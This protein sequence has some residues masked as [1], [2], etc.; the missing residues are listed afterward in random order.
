MCSML[1]DCAKIDELKIEYRIYKKQ[2]VRMSKFDKISAA[3]LKILLGIIVATVIL[4][5][6]GGIYYLMNKEATV[7]KTISSYTIPGKQAAVDKET[8]QTKIL[9]ERNNKNTEEVKKEIYAVQ[10]QFKERM[11]ALEKANVKL[12]KAIEQG[13][14]EIISEAESGV[15]EAISHAKKELETVT[16]FITKKLHEMQ[17]NIEELDDI[18]NKMKD[19]M[20]DKVDSINMKHVMRAEISTDNSQK[21]TIRIKVE[22]E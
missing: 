21:T 5:I 10:E 1:N 18:T 7:T 9:E 11:T 13:D 15:E 20:G 3:V 6:L 22:G 16:D 17:T 2:E 8:E 19:S 12:E 4:L 14:S